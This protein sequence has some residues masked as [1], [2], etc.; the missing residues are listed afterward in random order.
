MRSRLNTRL[1]TPSVQRLAPHNFSVQ[2]SPFGV[3]RFERR[4][5][6]RECGR[7]AYTLFELL[8]VLTLISIGLLVLVGSYSS[9]GTTHALTGATRVLQAGLEQARSLAMTRSAYVAFDYGSYETNDLQTV[10]GY[11]IHLCTNE[12]AEVAA[13]LQR[14]SSEQSALDITQTVPAAPY[15][16]LSSHVR[17]AHIEEADLSSTSTSPNLSRGV[18][19]FFRPDGSVW[20][21]NDTR[22]HYLCVYTQERFSRGG[23]NNAQPL[24]RYLRVDLATGLTTVITATQEEATP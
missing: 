3:Q 1:Q 15:Q 17:L 8:A 13:E 12:N 19:F 22:A 10:T 2:R 21:W 14:W 7:A 6:S 16:R 9:W 23:A 5:S 20:S 24:L 4:P 11:Q 18:T